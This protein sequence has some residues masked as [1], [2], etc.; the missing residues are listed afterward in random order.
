MKRLHLNKYSTAAILLFAAAVVFIYIALISIPGDITTSAF[1]ISGMVCAMTGIFALM[2]P[3]GEPVDR[4]LLEIF[5]APGCINLYSTTHLLGISGNAYFLPPALL[6][7][8][9]SHNSTQP[10]P[11]KGGEGSAKGSFRET[12]PP[13][14]VI[15]VMRPVDPGPY[16]EKCT[17]NSGQRGGVNIAPP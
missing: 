13:G 17:G 9:K 2:F 7:N 5:P 15:I 6:E 3:A 4:R 1:V 10:I 14:L 16:E 8:P 12:G 11:I